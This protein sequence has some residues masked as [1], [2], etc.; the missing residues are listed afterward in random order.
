MDKFVKRKRRTIRGEIYMGILANR[1]LQGVAILLAQFQR[2]LR[3]VLLCY[4][5]VE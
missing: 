1:N 5:L 3:H 4:D 2:E